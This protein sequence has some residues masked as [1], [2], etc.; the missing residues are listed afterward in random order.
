VLVPTKVAVYPLR[1]D[2]KVVGGVL[3]LELVT[4]HRHWRR[5]PIEP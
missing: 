2:D 1:D 3:T 4:G 5:K